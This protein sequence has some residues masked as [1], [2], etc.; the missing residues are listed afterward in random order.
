MWYNSSNINTHPVWVII[1]QRVVLDLVIDILYFPL[2]WYGPG[3][4]RVLKG[5]GRMISSVNIQFA[6]MLW[7]KNLFVPM[8]G[9]TD[10]QGRLMSI[11][12]RFANVIGRS[13]A[14]C[15]WTLIVVCLVALWI[16]VP[17]TVV[18]GFFDSLFY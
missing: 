7:I 5:A 4:V 11:V 1:L 2:W 10:W 13:I 17:I 9:Q 8:F 3:L 15:I 18:I 14:L 16:V 6:P 12:M